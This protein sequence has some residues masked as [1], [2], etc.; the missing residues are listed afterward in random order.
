MRSIKGICYIIAA[1]KEQL[2]KISIP[3]NDNNLIIAAD[4]GYD[5]LKELSIAPDIVLGDFDSIDNIPNHK[6]LIKH[7]A[8]KDDTDTLLSFKLGL[9]NGYKNFVIYGGTGG[10]FDH[11]IANVRTLSEIADND[12]RGFLV[13]N[14]T[15]ITV[16][17]KNYYCNSM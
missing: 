12:A 6:N 4:G 16:I 5:I 7:P 14:G 9:K 8:E 2:N 13:G 17:K 3:S 1:C 11:T 10:R 15:I